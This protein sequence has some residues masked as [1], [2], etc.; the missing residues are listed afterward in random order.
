MRVKT[1]QAAALGGG[2]GD[3]VMPGFVGYE[4]WQSVCPGLGE[5]LSTGVQPLEQG[6]PGR[7]R[8]RRK[9]CV[10]AADE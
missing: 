9:A 3:E 2:H 7:F 4:G 1:E 10:C 6:R 8:Q 5:P